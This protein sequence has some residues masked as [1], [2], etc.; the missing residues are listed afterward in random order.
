MHT[1]FEILEHCSLLHHMMLCRLVVVCGSPLADA[2]P[3]QCVGVQ[4]IDKKIRADDATHAAS[5]PL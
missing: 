1:C 4:V 2:Q 3:D 5:A